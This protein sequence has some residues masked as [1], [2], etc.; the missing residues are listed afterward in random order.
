MFSRAVHK[1]Q[2]FLMLSL[3]S[4]LI[5]DAD[6]AHANEWVAMESEEDCLLMITEKKKG[7]LNY[8]STLFISFD[9]KEAM[10][11]AA[12]QNFEWGLEPR[13]TDV[14]FRVDGRNSEIFSSYL[15]HNLMTVKANELLNR[16]EQDFKKG[17]KVDL[18]NREGKTISTFSLMGFTESFRSFES[19]V[20]PIVTLAEPRRKKKQSENLINVAKSTDLSS[21]D[22]LNFFL[23]AAFLFA[24]ANGDIPVG[25]SFGSSSGSSISVD[26]NDLFINPSNSYK[27][28]SR[29]LRKDFEPQARNESIASLGNSSVTYRNVGNTIRSSEGESWRRVGN[30]IRSSSGVSYRQVGNTIRSS[31]GESWRRVGNT[32][33][34]SSGVTWRPIGN[35]MRSSDG[36]TCRTIGSTVKC[37]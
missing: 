37:R 18:L 35:T 19:C 24:I 25:S 2:I 10:V 9:K 13:R 7:N 31:E 28:S 8:P 11:A 4:W 3:I 5:I 16:L 27:P 26:T 33:R 17:Y 22:A 30:T 36:T 32:I 20:K 29:T 1:I 12:V 14:Q 23:K 15:T 34:S 6:K 21:G